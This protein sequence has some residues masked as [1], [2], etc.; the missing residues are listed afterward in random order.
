MRSSPVQEDKMADRKIKWL[1]IF[2]LG[3]T[4]ISSVLPFSNVSAQVIPVTAE[5]NNTS[6]STSISYTE[7]SQSV[8]D[9][10]SKVRGV[11]VKDTLAL[12]VMQQPAGKDAFVSS[13]AGVA[14]QF[15]MAEQFGTVGLLAHNFAGGST[16]SDVK[17]DDEIYLL[18]RDGKT[19]KYVVKSVLIYQALAPNSASSDFKD[20]ASGNVISASALFEKVYKGDPHLVMQT[21]VARDNEMSW[22]RLFIIAEPFEVER[23]ATQPTP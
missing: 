5:G 18:Y 1:I 16:F 4:L 19:E 10:E 20:T 2:T 8:R 22:G 17:L 23:A 9:G 21:C 11:Y 12:R 7:F 15:R 14:T 13:V 6:A 3:I